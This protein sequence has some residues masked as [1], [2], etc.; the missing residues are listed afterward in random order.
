M[1]ILVDG[2]P[3][4]IGGIGSLVMNIVNYSKQKKDN[5]IFDFLLPKG[6]KYKKILEENGYQCWETPD[7]SQTIKYFN[8]VRKF[9]DVNKYDYLWFNNTSKVNVIL[10]LL[11]KRIGMA[12]IITHTHGVDF[13]EKGLKYVFFKVINAINTPVM[14]AMVDVPLACSKEAARIYYKYNKKL[15]CSVNVISNGIDVDKYIYSEKER[16]ER[17]HQLHIE[18]NQILLGAIGRLTKVKNYSFLLNV[19]G[20]LPV[21]YK[22]IILGDGELYETLKKEIQ[23]K[24]LEDRCYLLGNCKNVSSYLLAMDMFLLPSLNEGIPFSIIEAQASGLPCIASDSLTREFNITGLVQYRNICLEDEWSNAI[25]QY[26]KNVQRKKYSSVV[27]NKGYGI[28]T[29]YKK[30]VNSLKMEKKCL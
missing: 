19:L 10:P 20:K 16:V 17:R 25:L 27:R 24:K 18:E 8:F 22:L 4:G 9:F 7:F 30:F 11:A 15:L 21:K 28:D 3:R 13:E 26:S 6:S 2:M 12:K 14:F 23:E 29:S 1:K 5:L